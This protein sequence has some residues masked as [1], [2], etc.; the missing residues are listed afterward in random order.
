[1]IFSI[2]PENFPKSQLHTFFQLLSTFVLNYKNLFLW[3][4]FPILVLRPLGQFVVLPQ[5]NELCRNAQ[6][7][8]LALRDLLAWLLRSLRNLVSNRKEELTGDGWQRATIP[9]LAKLQETTALF[10]VSTW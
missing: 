4:P 7:P 9:E 1:M 5:L 2:L 3:N 10:L 8:W 6:F